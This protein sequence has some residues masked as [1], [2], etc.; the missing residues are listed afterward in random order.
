MHYDKELI[1][2]KVLPLVT[3]PITYQG[4]EVG[5]VH[6]DL[7]DTTI[8]YAFAFPDTYEVGMSHLGMKI[9]YSLLNDQE[10]IWCERVFAPWV[11][12]EE[13]MRSREIPLYALE[14]MDPI[15][16]FDF[17]GFTLQYEMSYTNLINMLEL[18]GIPLLSKDRGEDM[19]FIM[20]GGPCAY[21]PEPLADFVDIFV[22]GE[23]EEAI[24]ELMDAYR[25]F[26][27]E[28]GT[29]EDYLKKAVAIEGVYV[30]A[31][32]EA[33]YHEDGTLKAFTPLIGEAPRKIRKRFIKNLDNAYYP[34]AYVVPYT[35]T[36]HD[37]VSYEIFRGCG[38][39]CRFCQAGMIYRPIREKSLNTIEEG[40]KTLLKTTGYEEISLASLSSGDYS[41][42]ETLIEDLVFDYEDQCIGVSLPSLRIDS[43]S[44]DMLEQIQKI[45]KTGITLAPEAGTQRMRDVINKG[46][47]E[48][49][50]LSTVRTAFERGWGHIKLYFMIGLPTETE[51]DIAGIADLGQKV[52]DEYYAVPREE[53][54]KAVKIVLSTSC[55][56][57]KPFTPFQ[58]FGQ[59]TGDQFIEKQKMLKSLIKDR[60]ISYNWHD[61]SLSYLE[62]VFARGDR[63]LGR[64]L[65]KAHEAGC[66]FDGW[67]EHYD[68]Q[69]WLSVFEEAGVDPDFYALRSRSF[70]EL[71]P[72]DFIDIGVT[73]E[74]LQKEWEKSTEE[75]LTPY[76]REGCSNCGVMQ[77]S[78]GWKCHEHYTV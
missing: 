67:Q 26:K 65:L 3:K 30:P 39:G 36:V 18:G 11:D 52:L 42:I 54:N 74:F 13:Q 43:L 4:N 63:R 20:A 1:N 33:A 69:K 66:K 76:C 6:K 64:V 12:M 10:D 21:N 14:S 29:R 16:A 5:A 49:N 56:V 46:V 72:W 24:L 44:I 70:D 23:A 51:A 48:E 31:F 35:E 27:S 7:K 8:R 2:K 57:P 61:G 17:V 75:A 41:K 32:Y 37:R 22:I 78:K 40:I 19:P 50:L 58:W 68:H 59:N 45:R 73:K 62:A 60:K 15:S 47:T 38:R 53:R 71:L 77:F 28:G 25:R 55:F 9:L 34:K